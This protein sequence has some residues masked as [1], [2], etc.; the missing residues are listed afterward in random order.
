MVVGGELLVVGSFY[1]FSDV[2]VEES[3]PSRNDT[4]RLGDGRRKNK[5]SVVRAR[6]SVSS[7]GFHPLARFPFSWPNPKCLEY[8]RGL[9]LLMRWAHRGST[10]S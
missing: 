9:F 4:T 5:N 1:V 6:P 10:F 8:H 2:L 7:L 3:S